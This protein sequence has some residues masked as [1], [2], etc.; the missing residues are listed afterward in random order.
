MFGSTILDLTFGLIFTFLIIS[1]VTSTASFCFGAFLAG[2]RASSG[3]QG[4]SQ[5]PEVHRTGVER[6]QPR[7]G[8]FAGKRHRFR[9]YAWGENI[10]WIDL[11]DATA[12]VGTLCR[13][14]FNSDG[15]VNVGDIFAFLKAWFA[16]DPRADFNHVGGVSVQD[17]FD[18]L[19][20]W[21]GGC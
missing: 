16:R 15:T 14:D 9:G 11:D 12:Y 17:I 19:A 7:P 8:E 4:S 3:R 18:F 6:L 13:A 1:L 20:A 21:F 10:G 2:Q 5:R